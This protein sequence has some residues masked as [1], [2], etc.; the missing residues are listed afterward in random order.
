[1]RHKTLRIKGN[2]L[3]I[4]K[5]VKECLST[6]VR[7]HPY[8]TNVMLEHYLDFNKIVPEPKDIGEDWYD[9]R[10][11]NWG[12]KWQP[13]ET[14]YF[15]INKETKDSKDLDLAIAFSTA[16]CPPD[17]IYE[18]LIEQYKDTSLEFRVEYY[19]GGVGFAGHM[20]FSKGKITEEEYVE[21]TSN[22]ESAVK[23]YAYLIEHD[24]ESS[25]WLSD[26][27]YE[28]MECNDIEQ[29]IIEETVSQFEEYCRR[30]RIDEAAALYVEKAVSI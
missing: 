20:E 28:E 14:H 2:T 30:N 18:K 19:E 10:L 26:S 1:M 11:A 22:K 29:S 23:Y 8:S 3:D 25:E 6:E 12:T 9:W 17:K 27:I 15:E 16:W 5:F 13:C 4:S 21:Y 7:T 24:H